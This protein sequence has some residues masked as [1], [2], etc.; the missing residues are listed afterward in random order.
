MF[1]LANEGCQ[2]LVRIKLERRQKV[3][4][5][6]LQ[7]AQQGHSGSAQAQEVQGFALK[8]IKGLYTAPDTCIFPQKEHFRS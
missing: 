4:L 1:K 3:P 2:C 5:D 7:A 6:P 8:A